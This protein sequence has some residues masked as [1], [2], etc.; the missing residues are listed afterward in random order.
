M[1]R[2]GFTLLE[3]MIVVAIIGILATVAL[4]TLLRA[5]LRSRSAE[6]HAIIA[7]IRTAQLVSMSTTDK[8]IPCGVTPDDTPSPLPRNWT[9]SDGGFTQLGV[10]PE[11][12]VY[13]SYVSTAN[14]SATAFAVGAKANLDGDAQIQHWGYLWIAGDGSLPPFP[15]GVPIPDERATLRLTSHDVF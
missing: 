4:P 1:K 7:S 3:L 11:G 6:C 15:W 13:F 14:A 2:A 8:F 5:N 12:R 9:D 10:A